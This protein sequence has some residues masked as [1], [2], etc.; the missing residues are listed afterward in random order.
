MDGAQPLNNQI[1]GVRISIKNILCDL[2]F[3]IGTTID[4]KYLKFSSL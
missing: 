4:E 3:Q 1:L 2:N